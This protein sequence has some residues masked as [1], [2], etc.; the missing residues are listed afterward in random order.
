MTPPVVLTVGASDSLGGNGIQGDLRTLAALRV[1]GAS[2]V[3]SVLAR[4]TRGT[5][6][7]YPVPAN[8]VATQ[9]GTVLDDLPVSAVKTGT[10]A[11]ADA[12][13]AVTARARAGDLPNLVVDPVL[14]ATEGARKG[15]TAA[16]ERLLPYALIATPDREEAS[17]LL[18]W[19]VASPAD[20]AGAASQLAAG[21]PRYVVVTGGDLVVG[22]EAVDAMWL[23]GSV[24]MLR[25]PRLA[26]RN[27]YGTGSAFATAIAGRLA[28]GDSPGDAVARAKDFVSRAI[29]GAAGWTLGRG[30]GPI[31]HFGWS[32]PGR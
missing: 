13:A 14:T 8:V 7:L 28:L 12:C 5:A 21:G 19:Q 4:N 20:M 18:G 26:S 11:T 9:V 6:D 29:T 17:E 30:G 16:L 2:A 3:T 31:D 27:R 22:N 10:F 32:T 15:L 23:E 25:S 24:R 1:Y